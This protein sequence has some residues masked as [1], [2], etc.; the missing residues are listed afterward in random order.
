[1]SIYRCRKHGEH[2]SS[3]VVRRRPVTDGPDHRRRSGR[4]FAGGAARIAGSTLPA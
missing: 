1:M 4:L 3:V 2:V